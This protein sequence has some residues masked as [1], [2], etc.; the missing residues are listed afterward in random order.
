[1]GKTP[2]EFQGLQYQYAVSHHGKLGGIMKIDIVPIMTEFQELSGTM[3]CKVKLAKHIE[4]SS[5]FRQ[6]DDGYEIKLNP[7][8]IRGSHQLENQLNSIREAL[9][10]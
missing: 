10:F 1:M 7:L 9:T 4:T 5:S 6:S 8:R 3:K 2:Q